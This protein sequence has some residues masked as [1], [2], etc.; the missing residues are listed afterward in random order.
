MDSL[1]CPSRLSSVSSVR[2]GHW[3]IHHE[4]AH[5]QQPESDTSKVQT[6]LFKETKI[7][8]ESNDDRIIPLDGLIH[9][10]GLGVFY[11]LCNQQTGKALR[12]GELR[13][14]R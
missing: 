10:D 2:S 13:P 12:N 9:H 8:T 5:R 7:R 14:H 11:T 6:R 3:A 1:R 4:R